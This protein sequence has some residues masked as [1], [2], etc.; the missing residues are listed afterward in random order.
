LQE[1]EVGAGDIVNLISRDG[2]N[3]TVADITRLYV[4]EKDNLDLLHRTMRVEALPESWRDYFRQQIEKLGR[5]VERKP[6]AKSP[7]SPCC[8]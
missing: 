8:E 6:Q 7:A 1:G 5:S 4:S 3:V 2:N